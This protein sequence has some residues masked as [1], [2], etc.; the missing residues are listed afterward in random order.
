MPQSTKSTF[1][2]IEVLTPTQQLQQYLLTGVRGA[3]A[4]CRLQFAQR[5]RARLIGH[6]ALFD[7]R[8]A[9]GCSRPGRSLAGARSPDHL[10]CLGALTS[11]RLRT[12]THAQGKYASLGFLRTGRDWISLS[13]IL[14]VLG[15]VFG[16]NSAYKSV[17]VAR[18]N[19]R[20]KK[21]LASL[22]KDE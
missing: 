21:A 5:L 3:R 16:G 1:A 22:E 13:V 10:H 8:R 7:G 15:A 2:Y 11:T 4:R 19:S 12:P 17:N 6:T 18:T 9:C 14:V 20:R